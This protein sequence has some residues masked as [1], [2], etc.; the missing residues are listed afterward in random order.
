MTTSITHV[1]R[2][3]GGNAACAEYAPHQEGS[4]RNRPDHDKNRIAAGAD[5]R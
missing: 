2:G 5:A 4:Q 1:A 3:I